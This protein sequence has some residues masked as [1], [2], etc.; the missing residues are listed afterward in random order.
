MTSLSISSR[1]VM[2]V[3]AVIGLSDGG[4]S[5]PQRVGC[6]ST[7]RH[8]LSLS[9]VPTVHRLYNKL[10]VGDDF[11]PGSVWGHAKP[12]MYLM[13]HPVHRMQRGL[14]SDSCAMHIYCEAQV[15]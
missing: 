6:V 8:V 14:C 15:N 7:I 1:H 11:Q 10:M 2:E 5:C 12:M 3:M 9:S 4:N 13:S